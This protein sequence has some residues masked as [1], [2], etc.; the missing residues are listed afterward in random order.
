[1]MNSKARNR[2]GRLNQ[3]GRSDK[4]QMNYTQDRP[5]RSNNPRGPVGD[6]NISIDGVYKN[7]RY[8]HVVFSL[9][10]FNVQVQV[11][12]GKVY[13]GVLK[14]VSP[15]GDIVL[16]V[17]HVLGEGEGLATPSKDQVIPKLIVKQQDVIMVTASS[18]DLDHAVKDTF[19]DTGISKFN[20]EMMEKDLRELQPWECEGSDEISLEGDGD[21]SSNGWD[22]NDMFHTNATQ[23]NVKTSYDE[24]MEQYTT[25]LERENTEEYRQREEHARKIAEDIERN[26]NYRKRQE[27][28]NINGDDEE[29]RFS[30]VVRPGEGEAPTSH[31]G[32]GGSGKYVPPYKRQVSGGRPNS[33]RG[34]YN[35]QAPGR[36]SQQ[37]PQLST[38]SVNGTSEVPGR[39]PVPASTAGPTVKTSQVP[40]EHSQ[41][42][43]KQEHPSP[44]QA[45]TGGRFKRDKQIEELKRFSSDF[46]LDDTKDSMRERE[47]DKDS[48]VI[49]ESVS[50]TKDTSVVSTASPCTTTSV[51]VVSEADSSNNRGSNRVSSADSGSKT[52]VSASKQEVSSS[53]STSSASQSA[54]QRAEGD[55]SSFSVSE[56]KSTVKEPQAM[57][58]ALSQAEKKS[59]LNA[60][61]KEF[62][63]KFSLAS[64]QQIPTP[65]RPQT[66]S[67]IV[68]VGPNVMNPGMYQPQLFMNPANIVMNSQQPQQQQAMIGL[69]NHPP[70]RAVVSVKP[71]YTQSAVQA[72]TGQPLLANSQP[73]MYMLPPQPTGFLGQ[74][75]PMPAAQPSGQRFMTPTSVQG[76]VPN[77][78]HGSVDQGPQ[79]MQSFNMYVS[80]PGPMPA[81][82]APHPQHL[83]HV[84]PNSQQGQQMNPSLPSGGGPHHQHPA[85]SPVHTN[86]SQP[87]AVNPGQHPPSSGTPQ[88]PQGYPGNLQ[89]HPPLQPSPHNQ[90]SPQNMQNMPYPFTSH[91]GHQMQ[92]QGHG[93]GGGQNFSAPQQQQPGVPTS[94]TYSV[95]GHQHHHSNPHM[96]GQPQFVMMPSNQHHPPSGQMNHH[97]PHLT[98]FQGHHMSGGG[99]MQPHLMSQSGV[100]GIPQNPGAQGP[101]AQHQMQHFMSSGL[102][103]AA[104][105]SAIHTRPE[106]FIV[107]HIRK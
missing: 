100:Q 92:M 26:P 87:G 47:K 101:L 99:N 41:S 59:M 103:A 89:N 13:E 94:T 81:H 2:G 48:N 18:V 43:D 25:K 9:V 95:Q 71:D 30:S 10:G 39:P 14:T 84:I 105:S 27:L 20:G 57:D 4:R 50:E 72:A 52:A 53:V 15:K 7:Q 66:Q 62:V 77:S 5:M 86:P 19:T 38:E 21:R 46:K 104:L 97:H 107:Q 90:T 8:T 64:S 33:S 65:P 70:K 23:F 45:K 34:G 29:S 49:K 51:T 67:P 40:N 24:S 75:M 60:N 42:A 102:A 96:Q 63:P 82:M 56:T 98:Q 36:P 16:E 35:S 61:A 22:V 3:G 93:A 69:K 73:Y 31:P 37:T 83:P 78:M 80:Q 11:K 88:P 79:T 58:T 17:A 6:R 1:M 76:M 32:T 74:V 106:H 68:H 54:E 55:S 44:S 28:E 91:G 85:P 12:N